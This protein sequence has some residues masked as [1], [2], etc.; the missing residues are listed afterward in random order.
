VSPGLPSLSLLL[1]VLF[2]P[3]LLPQREPPSSPSCPS[4]PWRR[5]GPARRGRDARARPAP[6]PTWLR[7]APSS[8]ARGLTVS[9]VARR[10]PGARSR[11]RLPPSPASACPDEL[12]CAAL[13]LGCPAR[14]LASA[15]PQ[16]A[17][18]RA[19]AAHGSAQRG[20]GD[21]AWRPCPV[22]TACGLELGRRASGARPEL[23]WRGRGDPGRP[24]DPAMVWPAL[25]MAPAQRGLGLARLW[26]AR[27]RCPCVARRVR[28]SA[29]ACARPVRDASA[30]PCARVLAWSA[31]CFGTARRALGALVYPLD[32]P[33]Y[34]PPH[35]THA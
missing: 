27:P 30:R 34:P 5:F 15:P 12:P 3:L 28:S 18:R 4:R 20:R 23:G 11:P 21:P 22:P 19:R 14:S 8:P 6:R 31:R 9:P 25:S 29:P 35:V 17:R 13:G 2:L 33:V 32:A 16:R 24:P 10:R 26:L 7:R 1:S